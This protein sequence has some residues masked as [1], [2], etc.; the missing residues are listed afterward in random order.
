MGLSYETTKNH[1]HAARSDIAIC[2][3]PS[4]RENPL[5]PDETSFSVASPSGCS[6]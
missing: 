4:N 5:H 2:S 3:D 6:K 1:S